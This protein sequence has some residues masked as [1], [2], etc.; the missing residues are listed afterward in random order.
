MELVQ[1]TLVEVGRVEKTETPI[2]K[3]YAIPSMAINRIMIFASAVILIAVL[4]II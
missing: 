3:I 2:M 1:Y 4:V